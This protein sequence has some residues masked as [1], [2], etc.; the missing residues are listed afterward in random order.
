MSEQ[1]AAAQDVWERYEDEEWRQDQSHWRGV[2]RWKDDKRWQAIGKHTLSKLRATWRLLDRPHFPEPFVALEWG[3]G[4]GTN[5]FAMQRLCRTY[6][7]VDISPSNLAECERM[8]TQEGHSNLFTP[9]LLTAQPSDILAIVKEPID[10]FISTAVFQHFP[11]KEYGIEVL[12]AIKAVSKPGTLGVVQ[13]RYDNGNEKFRSITDLS[14]YRERHIT[15]NS[16]QIDE[17]WKILRDTGFSPLMIR[18][19]N[20]QVNY[21]TFIFHCT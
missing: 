19:I 1:H 14:E 6:Y 9:V 12:R 5:L 11:S 16:Y 10:V 7:G 21:A 15:A 3:P 18:D 4:G 8:I 2:G 20:A 13:I 17:F